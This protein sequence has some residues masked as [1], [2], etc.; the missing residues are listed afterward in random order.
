NLVEIL[1]TGGVRKECSENFLERFKDA[2][3]KEM[4]EFADCILEKR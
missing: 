1:D 3:L 4:Q 2:Y